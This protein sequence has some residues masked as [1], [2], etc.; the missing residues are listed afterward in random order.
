MATGWFCIPNRKIQEIPH[1]KEKQKTDKEVISLSH[2]NP[3]KCHL[4]GV[5]RLG[6]PKRKTRQ[7]HWRAGVDALGTATQ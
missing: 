2:P 7:D 3:A 6:A 5:F 1:E 4:R